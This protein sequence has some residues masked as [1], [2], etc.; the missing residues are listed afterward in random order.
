MSGMHTSMH[1]VGRSFCV[2]ALC[3]GKH[4]SSL[5]CKKP[6][7]MRLLEQGVEVPENMSRALPDLL[8]PSGTGSPAMHQSRL[9]AVLVRSVP[10]RPA[11]IDPTKMPHPQNRNIYHVGIN[12]CPNTNPFPTL[13]VAAAQH[14]NTKTRHQ[15]CCLS[16]QA[17]EEQ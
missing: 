1:H 7:E 16:S 4:G 8:F 9:D 6:A 15:T 3:K 2:N 12:S 10:G 14:A 13:D 17:G 5:I 11:H